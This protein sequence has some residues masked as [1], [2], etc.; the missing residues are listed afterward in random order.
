MNERT[1]ENWNTL[2]A[3]LRR[4]GLG[5]SAFGALTAATITTTSTITAT[6]TVTGG[7]LVTGGDVSYSGDLINNSVTGYIFVPLEPP[8]TSTSWDGD[9]RSSSGSYATLD[10]S[11]VFGIPAGVKAVAVQVL[12]RDSG[13]AAT[14]DIAGIRL[15]ASSVAG[16]TVDFSCAGL[17]NDAWSRDSAIVPCDS[18]GDIK[19]QTYASGTNTLDLYLQIYGYFI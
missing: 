13:S 10:L 6:G 4:L 5:K 2:V 15:G 8:A 17:T 1:P 9:Q 19:W 18:N 3:K 16:R 14:T 7:N 12:Q 11:A